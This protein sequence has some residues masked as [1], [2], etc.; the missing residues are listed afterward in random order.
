MKKT[1]WFTVSAT[2]FAFAWVTGPINIYV[3]LLASEQ[4]DE[5]CSS[6][7]WCQLDRCPTKRHWNALFWWKAVRSDQ[8]LALRWVLRSLTG[9]MLILTGTKEEEEEE[10]W[11]WLYRKMLVCLVTI[12]NTIITAD[13]LIVSLLCRCKTG[14]T[15][16]VYVLYVSTGC[17]LS[18]FFDFISC[19]LCLLCLL[20][21]TFFTCNFS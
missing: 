18:V 10:K 5:G 3:C 8:S 1:W 14:W 13:L 11:A 17:V 19:Q 12:D 6:T 16:S 4:S 20:E 9:A 15:F 7:S 2:V 21:I